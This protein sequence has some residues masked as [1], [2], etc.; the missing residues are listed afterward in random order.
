MMPGD[1]RALAL[2]V[3]GETNDPAALDAGKG[4]LVAAIELALLDMRR[5]TVREAAQVALIAEAPADLRMAV[6]DKILQMLPA[7]KSGT[8]KE[9]G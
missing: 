2:K 3:V 6:A 8:G 7:S 4:S 9:K 1:I 5:V